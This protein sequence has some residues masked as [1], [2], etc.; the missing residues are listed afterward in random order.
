MK[1]YRVSRSIKK[2]V[3]YIFMIVFGLIAV[4]PVW[5]LLI[6]ATR[7]TVQINSGLSI[8]PSVHAFHD[9]TDPVT[10]TVTKSNWYA[11]TSRGFQIAQ[12]FRNSLIISVLSTLFNVYFSAL[13]AYAIHIY[14]FKGRKILWGLIMT[15]IML[16]AS[17]SFIGFYQFMAK[18]HLTNTYI[19]LIVPSIAAAGT[20]LFM[21][22]YLE[23]IL[24]LE[25]IEAS[26]I[27]GAGEFMIFN[28]VVLPV[29]KPAIAAQAIFAFVASWNNFMT[30]F[31]LLSKTD[32]YTLPMLVQMLRGDIYRTEYGGIYL[33]IAIS[34]VPIIIFYAFMSRF[35]ISGLTMG[36][37]KE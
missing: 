19:P 4:V 35:I 30:P 32:M 6:N 13:T 31:V 1:N 28:K 22:Q 16:P 2:G 9:F 34:L 8:F 14:R 15:L 23:S 7:S 11:L 37:V 24:S 20:V 29:I 26:R 17:L 33:G 21:K 36:S 12:G 3:I 25:L 10:G 5:I 27:D 18:L